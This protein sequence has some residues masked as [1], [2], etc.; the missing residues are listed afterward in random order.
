MIETRRIET[1]ADHQVRE[2]LADSVFIDV[3]NLL[4]S[5]LARSWG[6]TKDQARQIVMSAIGEPKALRSIYMAVRRFRET[7]ENPSFPYIIARRRMLDLMRQQASRC[8]EVPLSTR[9]Q[10]R[11]LDS[12]LH[13]RHELPEGP[14]AGLF[15]EQR[16]R[17]VRRVLA[18]FALVAP[19]HAHLL[20]RRRLEEATYRELS[21]EL[22]C[23]L[24]A[25]RVRVHDAMIAFQEY[26]RRH[27]RELR[28]LL[29][30]LENEP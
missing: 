13:R 22:Q 26:V 8:V 28:D 29:V 9:E 30:H 1:E 21:A 4:V 7:G 2:L 11:H 25:A 27:H 19:Q 20:H 23:T 6:K 5:E 15:R 17:E 18:A 24:G 12:L 16:A 14:N 10:E 3:T